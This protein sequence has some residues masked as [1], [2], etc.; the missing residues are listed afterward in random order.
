MRKPE[1][2]SFRDRTAKILEDLANLIADID[3]QAD[4]K[5]EK[6]LHRRNWRDEGFEISRNNYKSLEIEGYKPWHAQS[7][8]FANLSIGK[9]INRGLNIY[10]R[11]A[12]WRGE[13][14]VQLAYNVQ[15]NAEMLVFFCMSYKG[16]SPSSYAVA[17]DENNR[18]YRLCSGLGFQALWFKLFKAILHG[19]DYTIHSPNSN[20]THRL[21]AFDD[22]ASAEKLADTLSQEYWHRHK[23]HRDLA[24]K[25]RRTMEHFG[26][27]TDI[28]IITDYQGLDPALRFV[29]REKVEGRKYFIAIIYNDFERANWLR[30]LGLNILRQGILS[31]C[32]NTFIGTI[33]GKRAALNDRKLRKYRDREIFIFRSTISKSPNKIVENME[34]A[35]RR[36]FRNII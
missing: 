24:E 26:R 23:N 28:M 20:T 25:M 33:D 12:I 5:V 18:E 10:D 15:S 32:L 2:L 36:S 3:E 8:T 21:S 11:A 1:F 6:I 30:R 4:L 31:G 27:E 34:D 29:E 19:Y 35:L 17:S 13:E 7:D 22:I 14:T 16:S 9:S